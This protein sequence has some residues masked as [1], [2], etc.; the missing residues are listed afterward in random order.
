MTIPK[1]NTD[2]PKEHAENIEKYISELKRHCQED[3]KM[4]TDPKA[5]ALFETTADILD[6]L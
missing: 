3:L 1:L 6:G 2:N 4:V 5:K